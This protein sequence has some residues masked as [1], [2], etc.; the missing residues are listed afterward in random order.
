[1]V[2]KNTIKKLQAEL[3]VVKVAMKVWPERRHELDIYSALLSGRIGRTKRA[4]RL[5]KAKAVHQKVMG[6][7]NKTK[8]VQHG[9][10]KQMESEYRRLMDRDK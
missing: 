9:E 7:K 6:S 1:M 3:A 5:A 4:A 8:A 10:Y 2:R